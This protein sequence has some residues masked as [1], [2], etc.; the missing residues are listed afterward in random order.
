[1]FMS[2]VFLLNKVPA[3]W[4]LPELRVGS[5]SNCHHVGIHLDDDRT[6]LDLLHEV[7]VHVIY[8]A[9]SNNLRPSTKKTNLDFQQAAHGN[10]RSI[11]SF[12]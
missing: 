6:Y 3:E 11:S 9:M 5:S 4:F 7:K 12:Q 8:V 2:L 1:M 10:F